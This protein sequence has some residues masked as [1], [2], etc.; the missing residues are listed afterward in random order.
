MTANVFLFEELAPL[1]C[2]VG[3]HS[4]AEHGL[5]R[6]KKAERTILRR[7]TGKGR[8]TEGEE[9]GR[10]VNEDREDK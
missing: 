6:R 5:W 10:Q 2:W 1:Y 4:A 9:R 8:Q 3:S 7:Q